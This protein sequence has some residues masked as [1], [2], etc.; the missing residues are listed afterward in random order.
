[1]HIVRR[2]G[3]AWL[4]VLDV[5]HPIAQRVTTLLERRGW[6]DDRSHFA[7]TSGQRDWYSVLLQ[8]EA[9]PPV[10]Q[11]YVAVVSSPSFAQ[12]EAAVPSEIVAHDHDDGDQHRRVTPEDVQRF[13]ADI[14]TSEQV[15]QIVQK[16]RRRERL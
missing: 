16:H 2:T 15:K 4:A 14:A 11:P 9:T 5:E 1:M 13:V 6:A 8:A 12:A 3:S 7:L 10:G